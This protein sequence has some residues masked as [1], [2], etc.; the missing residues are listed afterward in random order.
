MKIMDV[1]QMSIR[2]IP[3]PISRYTR[4]FLSN[5]VVCNLYIT[6][7]CNLRCSMCDIWKRAEPKKELDFKELK[8]LLRQLKKMGVK[9][10][11]IT[12]G[13]PL[14]KKDILKFVKQAKK[15]G[16]IVHINSNTAL[17]NSEKKAEDIIN[18]GLD[19]FTVS[20]DGLKKTHDKTRNVKGTFKRAVKGTK[21]LLKAR[22]KLK[23]GMRIGTS[24]VIMKSNLDEIKKLTLMLKDLGVDAIA[25][26]PF[27]VGLMDDNR[28]KKKYMITDKKDVRKLDSLIKW[29]IK[30]KKDTG[31]I[32]NSFE[33]LR[34]VPNYFSQKG[35]PSCF[36][37]YFNIDLD[38]KGNVY[39][40]IAMKSVGNIREHSLKKIWKNKGYASFRK[41]ILPKCQKCFIGCYGEP[42]LLY[43][44]RFMLSSFRNVLM[45][46]K[47]IR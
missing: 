43:N 44:P 46:L 45:K 12:G 33:F 11:G 19:S 35:V 20:F 25:F 1:I 15:M 5:P 10:I 36:A 24:T 47:L 30:L 14:M 16:F 17:V 31:I 40:C 2:S 28:A 4:I 37:G 27:T 26:Q 6:E 22:K 8:N 23:K 3:I 41:W 29:L 38:A 9:L 42:S 34:L 39:P 7:M 32:G 21:L 13:E 18:S